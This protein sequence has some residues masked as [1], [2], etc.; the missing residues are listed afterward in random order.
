MWPKSTCRLLSRLLLKSL[1][2]SERKSRRT[3]ISSVPG[4][5]LFSKF[6]TTLRITEKKYIYKKNT[7]FVNSSNQLPW[8]AEQLDIKQA[9]LD[10]ES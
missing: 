3:S 7:H 8:K 9:Y 4:A 6:A 1:I 2:I 10:S 5:E